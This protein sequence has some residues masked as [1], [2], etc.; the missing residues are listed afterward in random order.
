MIVQ[1]EGTLDTCTL[2]SLTFTTFLA[3]LAD[4]KLIILF[5]YCSQKRGFYTF[6]KYLYVCSGKLNR[7]FDKCN[8]RQIDNI[9][10]VFSQNNGFYI[11]FGLFPKEKIHMRCQS[12]LSVEIFKIFQNFVCC[13]IYPECKAI[14]EH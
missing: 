9:V 4:D 11:S 3:I 10:F 12:F 14:K 5:F 6:C 8:K 1:C 7:S 2:V 13:L